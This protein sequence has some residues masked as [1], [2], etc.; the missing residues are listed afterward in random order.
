MKQDE[1]RRQELSD[2]LRSRRAR[3]SPA[4]VGLSASPRRRTAGLR[5]E[6]VAQLAGIAR[7]GIRGLNRS[8]RLPCHVAL[9]PIWLACYGLIPSSAYSSSSSRFASRRSIVPIGVDG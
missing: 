5:R 6:E 7:P 8:V 3:V 4:D 2:F 1:I 9:W